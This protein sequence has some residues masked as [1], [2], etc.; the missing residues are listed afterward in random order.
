MGKV[1]FTAHIRDCVKVPKIIQTGCYDNH[2]EVQTMVDS[3]VPQNVLSNSPDGKVCFCQGLDCD[4]TL[5]SR[6]LAETFCTTSDVKIG[7]AW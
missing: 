6:D 3:I 2:A 4:I 5:S 7:S 1:E